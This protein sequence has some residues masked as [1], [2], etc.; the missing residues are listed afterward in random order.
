MRFVSAGNLRT[1]SIAAM[2]LVAIALSSAACSD[3]SNAT[4]AVSPRPV[5]VSTPAV[6]SSISTNP[7]TDIVTAVTAAWTAKDAS[8]YAAPYAE[9]VMMVSPRGDLVAGRDALRAQ[10]VM[11]FAGPFAGSTQTIEVRDVRFLTGTIAIVEQ[12]VTL[13]GYAFL[14]PGLPSTGGV[15]RTR[16][17]WVVE[18][19]RGR[20]EIVF[21]QMTPRL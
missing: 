10:H 4:A 20:W 9:D 15:V 16:V 6:S 19:R 17:T 21:Q 13:T 7:I 8:A 11:L 3:G 18:K 1:A 2:P 5:N 14:P 12:D